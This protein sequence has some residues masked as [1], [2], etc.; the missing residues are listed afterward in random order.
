MHLGDINVGAK[1][2]GMAS[3]I[4]FGTLLQGC[5]ATQPHRPSE[6]LQRDSVPFRATEQYD[7]VMERIR[8]HLRTA[9]QNN[10]I[11]LIVQVK[12]ILADA[13]HGG[14]LPASLSNMLVTS[15]NQIAGAHPEIRVVPYDPNYTINMARQGVAVRQR[16]PVIVIEGS[17]TEF[18]QDLDSINERASANVLFG[19]GRGET[20]ADLSR[21]AKASISRVGIDL[22][23][24]DFRNNTYIS[25][26]STRNSVHLLNTSTQ[27]R[28]GFYIMGNGFNVSG[29]VDSKQGIHRALRNLVDLSVIEALSKLLNVPWRVIMISDYTSAEAQPVI[30]SMVREFE[31]KSEAQLI[32][33]IQREINFQN[34][35]LS[36][37]TVSVDGV[38]GRITRSEF[39]LLL[40]QP[41]GADQDIVHSHVPLVNDYMKLLIAGRVLERDPSQR[42][43]FIAAPT[44]PVA[45]RRTASTQLE[46]T[47]RGRRAE[48]TELRRRLGACTN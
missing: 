25:H 42:A 48:C 30:R 36:R 15:L 21:S 41:Y 37:P 3:L 4:A 13:A 39:D 29:S 34:G 22:Q 32:R 6:E 14:E 47:P 46:P 19:G 7:Q 17:I 16:H 12:P 27:T 9:L 1:H 31:D 18:D 20:D 8:T 2:L 26:A 38:M 10:D 44:R 33:L 11:Q 35:M 43:L 5:V 23:V 24:I 28:G 40:G 45:V